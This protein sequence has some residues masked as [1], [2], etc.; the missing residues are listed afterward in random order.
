VHEVQICD[1]VGESRPQKHAEVVRPDVGE[2]H[3]LEAWEVGEVGIA[4]FAEVSGRHADSVDEFGGCSAEQGADETGSAQCAHVK[5][6]K[7][8]VQKLWW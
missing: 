2:C 7:N 6:P 5:V 4:A 3:A 1:C 8:G